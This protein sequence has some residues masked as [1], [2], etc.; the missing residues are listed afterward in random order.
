MVLAQA[1][2]VVAQD[3]PSKPLRIIT[4]APGG[5]S[6]FTSRQIAAP[7]SASIGQ[8]VVVDNRA[9]TIL[10][11]DGGAK[12]PPDGYYMF[13][14]GSSAWTFQIL[15]KAPYD[16]NDFV[17]ISLVE[18][19]AN[20]VSVHPS[21]PVKSIKELIALAKARPGE[22]NYA[23]ISI[24]GPQHLAGELFKSMAGV[25]IL[26]VPYKANS[27]AITALISGEVQLYISDVGLLLPHA[28]SG[29]L[30]ALAVTSL[31]R[32]ALVP[33]LPTV[34]ASGLPGYEMI[35]VTGVFAPPKT[36]ATF[37][38]RLNREIVRVLNLPEI[39][40]KFL[41]AGVEIIGS[42]PEQ[43]A[44]KVKSDLVGIAKLVKDAGIKVQ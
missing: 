6:D 43:L 33:D 18:R 10:A 11:A 20:I 31:D 40:E 14:V 28:K 22:L 5:G 15:Q 37:V 4:G 16:A 32:S 1:A 12:S 19:S 21:V 35:G 44:A 26:H 39:K 27:P 34:A 3:Y 17:P 9:T 23:S 42:T 13:M 29:K 8:P 36:P 7:I 2:T 41:T 24:G 30:R 38:S 25:N